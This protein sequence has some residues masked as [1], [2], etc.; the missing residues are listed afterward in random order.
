MNPP[1]NGWES[2]L[3]QGDRE[4]SVLKGSGP[5]GSQS[6]EPHRYSGSSVKCSPSLMGL[7]IWFQAVRGLLSDNGNFRKH[8]FYG[9]GESQRVGFKN[10]I[11]WPDLLSAFCFL[12]S[13]YLQ[14]SS[15]CPC[16]HN[17]LEPLKP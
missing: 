2:A 3:D 17:G 11:T 10:F 6:G 1:S 5:R 15:A 14:S 4:E 7:S 9:R 12:P 13:S 16:Y 8:I